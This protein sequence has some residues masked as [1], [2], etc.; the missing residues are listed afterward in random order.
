MELC[1]LFPGAVQRLG[2]ESLVDI[3]SKS[4]GIVPSREYSSLS[5]EERQALAVGD[6]ILV[7][8]PHPDDETIGCGGALCWHLTEGDAVRVVFLTSGEK[9]GHGRP[10]AGKVA[11]S[12]CQVARAR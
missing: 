9:G 12:G 5:T 7:I 3:G 6:T 8:R 10:E 4:E 2:Q 1:K 11:A